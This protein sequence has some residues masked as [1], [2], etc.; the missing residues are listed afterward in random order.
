MKDLNGKNSTEENFFNSTVNDFE[1]GKWMKK[2]DLDS[3]FDNSDAVV[4]L[5]E[6][7]EYSKLNWDYISNKMRTPAWVFDARSILEPSQVLKSGL[8][9]WR[10]G[11]GSNY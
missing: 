2:N 4:L 3:I 6:W 5:T 9:Y 1:E 11:D 7:N 8:N 10:I